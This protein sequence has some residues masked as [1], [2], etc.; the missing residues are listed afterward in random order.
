MRVIHGDWLENDFPSRSFDTA[1][2][3]ESLAHMPDK[4]A[5]FREL[6][7]TLVP[8]GQAAISCWTT[9]PEPSVP[10]SLL[11]RYLCLAGA[12]PSIG[13]LKSYRQLATRAGLNVIQARDLTSCVEPTWRHIARQSL[14]SSLRPRFLSRMLPIVLRRPVL[15]GVIPAMILAY[16]TGTLRY[17]AIWLSKESSDSCAG[18]APARA[19]STTTPHARGSCDQ[20]SPAPSPLARRANDRPE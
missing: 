17:H 20:L 7:R 8:G 1:I 18:H 14:S 12:L 2:A 5:F 11:L 9:V 6:A 3:I 16:R 4:Q 19:H 10:E 15:S 13:T